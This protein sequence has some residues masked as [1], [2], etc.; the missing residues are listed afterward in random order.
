MTGVGAGRNHRGPFRV[1]RSVPSGDVPLVTVRAGTSEAAEQVSGDCGERPML[2][3]REEKIL[4]DLERQMDGELGSRVR[5]RGTRLAAS[6]WWRVTLAVL[7]VVLGV[8]LMSL[9]LV[10]NGLLLIVMGAI[11]LG[12]WYRRRQGERPAAPPS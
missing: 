8:F 2:D 6:L 7:G 12:L 1:S 4:R 9:A 3:D 11:P 10:G 5:R